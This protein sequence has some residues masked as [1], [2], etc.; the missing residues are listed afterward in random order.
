[1]KS[2]KIILII[3]GILIGIILLDTLQAKLFDN[4]PFIKITDSYNDGSILKKDKG[5]FVHT[6]VYRNGE[7]VTVYRWEKYSPVVDIKVNDKNQNKG[8]EEKM[9]NV[10]I[11]VIINNKSYTSTIEDNATTREF[12]NLLPQEFNMEEL[13]GNEKYVYMDYL[14][15]TNSVNPGHIM[16]G[17]I[18]LYGDNC[19]VIFYKSFDTT[20]SYT[21]IGHID[22]LEDLGNSN[23]SVL[24]K[25]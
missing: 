8:E 2:I 25:K 23:V 18:M 6:Y 4:R 10:S 5:I 9:S 16:A 17:D 7:K 19:L 3:L 24:L 11:D 13:N 1:M 20:Y 15:P 21:R 22:N 14:L 12:L